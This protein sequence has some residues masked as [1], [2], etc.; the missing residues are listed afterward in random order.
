MDFQD[1]KDYTLPSEDVEHYR[2]NAPSERLIVEPAIIVEKFLADPE[3]NFAIPPFQKE[4]IDFTSHEECVAYLNSVASDCADAS[5]S[6]LGTTFMGLEQPVI[7]FSRKSEK[8][9]LKAF[10]QA[11]VHGN[12]CSSTESTLAV[13][14]E[15]AFGELNSLLDDMDIALVPIFNV[16][17][18]RHKIRVNS[19][20]MDFN[21]DFAKAQTREVQNL[22]RFINEFKPHLMIDNHEFRPHRKETLGD[23]KST[24]YDIMYA[25]TN[26]HNVP[27]ILRSNTEKLFIKGIEQSLE[28]QDIRHRK[29]CLINLKDDVLTLKDSMTD[30]LCAKNAFAFFN[31]Y[32]FLIECRGT[33]LGTAALKRRVYNTYETNKSLLKTLLENRE[34]IFR[35]TE[36][37]RTEVRDRVAKQGDMILSQ[38]PVELEDQEFHFLNIL[39]QTVEA[40]KAPYLDYE[41]GSADKVRPWPK[42]Y[43]LPPH[44][45]EIA[46]SLQALGVEMSTTDEWQTVDV[47]TFIVESNEVQKK[48]Y[49]TR[50]QNKMETRVEQR[51]VTLP[52][53]SFY[54]SCA[55]E[56]A[57]FLLG[58]EPE[59][60]SSF[61][62]FGYVP[63]EEGEELGIFRVC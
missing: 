40:H 7:V 62:S 9:K 13:V 58:L 22:Y 46:E 48:L 23:H 34:E 3:R 50:F 63:V 15:I 43:L 20:N 61:A 5:V 24:A 17:G 18:A 8:P 30:Y 32:S 25:G 33:Y 47:E 12:E 60:N 21:R 35:S 54:I 1:L 49:G 36:E 14:S 11:R 45:V 53:G 2:Y 19:A 55:Q 4:Q 51:Q 6:S 41:Q 59:G 57:N 10:I 39:E 28:G 37:A 31:A 29:Y 26:N 16:D 44:M 42:A 38:K 27:E 56:K 52:P